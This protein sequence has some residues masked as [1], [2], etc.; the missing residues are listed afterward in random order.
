MIDLTS[1]DGALVAASIVAGALVQGA[2]GFGFALVC[3]PVI[4]LVE[5]AALPAVVLLLSIPLNTF[6]ALRERP[7]IDLDG[8]HHLLGGLVAGTAGGTAIMAVMPAASLSVAFGAAIVVVSGLSVLRPHPGEIRHPVRI[9]AG[10][11][12]GLINTVAATGG[13]P[14]ALLYQRRPGPQLRSTL[15]VVFLIS[16]VLSLGGLAIAGRLERQ[17]ATTAL[18]LLP[19]L[20]LGA[21]ASKAAARRLDERWLRPAVLTFAAASGMAAIVRGIL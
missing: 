19:A 14:V 15:A 5:P 3:A 20:A 6:V 1:V 21:L 10:T 4:A 12:S 17:H 13:P 2:V 7:H 8:I 16:I 9:A 11:A 18:A